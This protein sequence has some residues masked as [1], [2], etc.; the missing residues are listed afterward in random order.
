MEK[1]LELPFSVEG[2]WPVSRFLI[3]N[4]QGKCSIVR[5]VIHKERGLLLLVDREAIDNKLVMIM[6]VQE[7]EIAA[8]LGLPSKEK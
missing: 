1:I 6:A 5:I 8:T 2:W 4:E 3:G 7:G